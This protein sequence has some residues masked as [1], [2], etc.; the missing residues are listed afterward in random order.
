M[1]RAVDAGRPASKGMP[2]GRVRNLVQSMLLANHHRMQAE[3]RAIV[4]R[5]RFGYGL[6]A[7]K[8]R[9]R[10]PLLNRGLVLNTWISCLKSVSDFGFRDSG[11]GLSYGRARHDRIKT[12]WL[13]LPI[14]VTLLAFPSATAAEGSIEILRD[15]WGIPHVFADTDQGAFYGLGYATAEDRAFQMTYSLRIIQGRLAQVVGEVRQLARDETSIDHDRKMRTFGFHRAAQRTAAALDPET[16]GLLQA[17]CDGVN[18]YFRD[19]RDDLH[20]LFARLGL[21]P[22]PWTPADCLMSWWHLAQFFATDGTRDLI[23]ARN[24]AAGSA[25]MRGERGQPPARSDA[26][27]PSPPAGAGDLAPL[28]PDDAPAVVKRSDV[29]A[30]WIERVFGYAR[31]HGLGGVGAAGG[32][33]PKFSHAW[34]VGGRRTTTG[35]AVLVSDPQTPVRNPSLLYQFHLQG[36][37][38]CGARYPR[39]RAAHWRTWNRGIVPAPRHRLPNRAPNWPWN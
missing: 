33:G 27:R 30:E 37:T 32:E 13:F 22:E 15:P 24:Q 18:A 35:S 3:V 20:P 11:F 31:E 12:N 4:S 23:A 1:R 8:T 10:K 5:E 14:L 36:A 19:R 7:P 25:P 21:E 26:R 2:L 29:S 38:Y 28:P 17:Y 34:V 16:R 39:T 9:M 6:E